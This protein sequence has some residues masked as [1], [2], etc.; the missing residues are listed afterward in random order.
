MITL[1]KTFLA[2]FVV[3]LAVCVASCNSQQRELK[4]MIDQ[5]NK[6]SGSFEPLFAVLFTFRPGACCR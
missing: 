3:M 4:E 1:K 2:A 6:K 5:A